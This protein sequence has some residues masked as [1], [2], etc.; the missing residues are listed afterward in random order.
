MSFAIIAA[1]R[2]SLPMAYLK[3]LK[4]EQTSKEKT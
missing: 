2:G 4:V 3:K 1:A